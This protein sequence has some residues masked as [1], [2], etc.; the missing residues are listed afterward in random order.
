MVKVRTKLRRYAV[1]LVV[2]PAVDRPAVRFDGEA[3]FVFL[4]FS[5]PESI[6]QA[7]PK[8]VSADDCVS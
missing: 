6:G 8:R 2:L 4:Q 7:R 1:R 3:F 5:W